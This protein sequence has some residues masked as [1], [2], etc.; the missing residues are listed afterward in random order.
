MLTRRILMSA[1]AVVACAVP[2]SATISY[3]TDPTSFGTAATGLTPQSVSFDPD[4]GMS[5]LSLIVSGI[6]FAGFDGVPNPANVI[7]S[8]NLGSPWPPGSIL[9]RSGTG[10]G[11]TITFVANVRAFSFSFSSTS[12]FGNIATLAVVTSADNS[13]STIPGVFANVPNFEGVVADHDIGSAT[14]NFPFTNS[15]QLEFGG[16]SFDTPA[17]DTGSST[18]ELGSLFLIGTGLGVLGIFRRRFVLRS[19]T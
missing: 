6:T 9:E 19:R 3:Y 5:G 13:S 17:S 10:G 4:L 1:L 11:I 14:I 7:V 18:P 2:A 16:F 15:A 8:G 12:G